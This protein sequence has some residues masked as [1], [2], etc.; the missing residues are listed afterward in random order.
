MFAIDRMLLFIGADSGE[1]FQVDTANKSTQRHR[2]TAQLSFVDVIVWL[3]AKEEY[4]LAEH[5]VVNAQQ[6]SFWQTDRQVRFLRPMLR[7]HR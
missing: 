1:S 7:N 4:E 6:L 3:I 2:V 5:A